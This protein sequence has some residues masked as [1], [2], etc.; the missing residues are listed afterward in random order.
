ML[1]GEEIAWRAAGSVAGL[2]LTDA[3]WRAFAETAIL[4]QS[5]RCAYEAEIADVTIVD[6]S[7]SRITIP[8]YAEE[9]ESLRD[10]FF[11]ALKEVLGG[12]TAMQIFRRLGRDL[13]AR[14]GGFGVAAQTLELSLEQ[15][16]QTA[17]SLT[18]T[19]HYWN[20]A[21]ERAIVR[22]ETSWPQWEDPHGETW[23][24]LLARVSQAFSRKARG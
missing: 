21:E 10:E 15:D 5:I 11:A 18:R 3:Q 24:P 17:T 9:G 7:L 13:D 20:S 6:D 14:F 19:A 4:H 1:L 8:C 23:G 16:G 22:Q 12:E 2:E